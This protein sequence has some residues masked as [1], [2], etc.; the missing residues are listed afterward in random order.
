MAPHEASAIFVAGGTVH[1]TKTK[2]DQNA[3]DG[4]TIF[5]DTG[6]VDITNSA[7][8][9]NFGGPSGAAA[10][11]TIAKVGFTS[12]EVPGTLKV[13]N[14][15]FARMLVQMVFSVQVA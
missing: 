1:V 4:S 8:T 6:S 3:A 7:F 5:L 15:T 12:T 10:G 13:T 2:F 11:I 9:Q 14:T